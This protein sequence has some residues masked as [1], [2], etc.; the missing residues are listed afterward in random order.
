MTVRSGCILCNLHLSN[1]IPVCGSPNHNK[2]YR[3]QS[4]LLQ[5]ICILLRL[6]F[7]YSTCNCCIFTYSCSVLFYMK[8]CII[9]MISAH[10]ST[11]YVSD[12][13]PEIVIIV[14][15]SW[16]VPSFTIT[17]HLL[18]YFYYGLFHTIAIHSNA[19]T[20]SLCQIICSLQ[21]SLLVSDGWYYSHI[22]STVAFFLP[23]C[24]WYRICWIQSIYPVQLFERHI[25]I[26]KK[27]WISLDI[28]S[29]L[30]STCIDNQSIQRDYGKD[31]LLKRN[32][33]ECFKYDRS[34]L[35]RVLY[36]LLW[37]LFHKCW[38]SRIVKGK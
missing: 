34:I 6:Q 12:E 21:L 5:I 26:K 36:Y 23:S 18:L 7:I 2:L 37:Q 19:Y 22:L 17:I 4:Y 1:V 20:Q 25:I 28:S 14:V 13:S 16:S 8:W 15:I 35:W 24:Y 31:N 27:A 32:W 11:K 9:R 10:Y 38:F 30:S 3:I 29:V 33:Q